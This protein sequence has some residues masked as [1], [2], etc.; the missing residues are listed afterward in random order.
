MTKS[1]LNN[2]FCFIFLAF[3]CLS[4]TIFADTHKPCSRIDDNPFLSPRAKEA[5]LPHL[6]PRKHPL[7]KVLDSIFLETRATVD[8]S[9]FLQAGFTILARGPRSFICVAKHKALKGYLVKVFFDNELQKKLDKDSWLWLVNRCEG[10]KK[11]KEAIQKHQAHHFVVPT[12]WIYCLPPKP[13]PPDTPQHTRH[14]AIL[15]VKRMNLVSLSRNY[16]AWKY[17]ITKEHLNELFE[18]IRSA[19]G[20]SYRPDNIAYM[21]NGQ[22]AFIDTEYPSRGPDF[23]SIRKHLNRAMRFY[24]DELV[25]SHGYV[26]Y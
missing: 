11:I 17:A 22:F 18:I 15:I 13:S 2:Y 16:K 6:L 14:L 25:R 3:L 26:I 8:E 23:Q 21:K 24:W 1:R 9:A 10:A 12:K 5:I 4:A 20:S 7:H 19:K